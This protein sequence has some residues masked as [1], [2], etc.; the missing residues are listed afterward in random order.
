[1]KTKL[2]LNCTQHVLTKDQVESVKEMNLE[3]L[4]LKDLKAL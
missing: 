1:M 2:F 3:I 4:D